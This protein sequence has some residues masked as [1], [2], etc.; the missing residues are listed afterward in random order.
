MRCVRRFLI[1]IGGVPGCQAEYVRVPYA[2]VN[3]LKIPDD[4]PDEKALYLS[5]IVGTS[6]HGAY[7]GKVKEG[8]VVAI[9]GLGIIRSINFDFL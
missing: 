9:W 8:S 2:E 5:D 6:Y 1:C 4:V 3:C 7:L